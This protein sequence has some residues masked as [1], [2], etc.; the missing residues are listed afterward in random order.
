MDGR[1]SNRYENP[2][3]NVFVNADTIDEYLETG[4]VTSLS[5]EDFIKD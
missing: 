2:A 3:V 4:A 5:R 1:Y